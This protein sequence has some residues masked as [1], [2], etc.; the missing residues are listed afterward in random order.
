MRLI[1]TEDALADLTRL[2][3]FIAEKNPEA[4]RR[5]G[6]ELANRIESIRTFPRM[7]WSVGKA[8][9][10]EVIRDFAFGK[11]VVRYAVHANSIAILRIWHHFEE[12]S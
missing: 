3:A 9:D 4:A 1:Y 10:P 12:R 6:A 8:P 2:R 7:G 5:I 11:Y